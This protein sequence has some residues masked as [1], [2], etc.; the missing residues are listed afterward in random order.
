MIQN[1][2]CLYLPSSRLI[3]F[4]RTNCWS[5]ISLNIELLTNSSTGL[6]SCS[7]TL[8]N[9]NVDFDHLCTY[10]K[11]RPD[12]RPVQDE[13]DELVVCSAADCRL[14]VYSSVNAAKTFWLV[15]PF[16]FIY[17]KISYEIRVKG[18]NFNIPNL[19]NLPPSTKVEKFK[20]AS[21]AIFRLAPSDYHRFHSPIDCEVGDIENV[22]GH[23]YTGKWARRSSMCTF[24]RVT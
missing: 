4:R 11:L 15:L 3:R 12:A 20:N 13:H 16:F 18:Q 6:T 8:W 23:F 5:L 17:F 19:L 7:Y 10:R 14:T 24:L 1:R 9:G 21:L 22:P 2:L